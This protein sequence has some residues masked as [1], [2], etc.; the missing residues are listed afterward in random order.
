MNTTD[1]IPLVI[2]PTLESY[3]Q[4][5]RELLKSY[6][7]LDDHSVKYVL[8][9]HPDPH[10]FNEVNLSSSEFNMDDARL[11]I[12]RQHGFADYRVFKS[13]LTELD[14]ESSLTCRFEQAADAIVSGDV[15]TLSRLIA[16]DPALISTRSTRTHR[17]TLL[18]Y[19]AANG[20]EQFRQKS[21]TNATSIAGILLDAG[22][23][24]DA[25]AD[26]YG[27]NWHT[28][29]DLLVSS[30]HPARAG[31]QTAL[32]EKLLD[33]GAAVNGCNNDCSPLLTAISFHYPLAAE[34]LVRRGARVD[35]IVAA[36]ALGHLGEVSGYLRGRGMLKSQT[37]TV[38]VPWADC[39]SNPEKQL[40]LALV[41]AA[42]HNRAEVVEFLLD[43]GVSIASTDFCRWTALHWAAYYG[44]TETCQILL[45]RKAPLEARNEFGGTVL[46]QTL[47]AT[48]HEGVAPHHLSI[49]EKLVKA[50]AR[51]HPWWLFASLTPPL[52]P[53]VAK[54]LGDHT[55][56]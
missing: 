8:K 23:E 26:V 30:V 56:V 17:A 37:P 2:Q 14:D 51:I 9:Y 4:K 1:V 7:Q 49:I 35:T 33:Y 32:V 52:D 39:R 31:V 55:A 5:S 43:Q 46:D 50:G 34:T 29:L 36:A 38:Q 40:E 15:H 13:H 12:A 48:V 28:T 53:R 11:T 6:L 3:E 22:S 27:S 41:W 24:V 20:V 54:L 25:A 18:H 19:L 10:K 45:R 42:M 21:A 44:C 47:W 16:D